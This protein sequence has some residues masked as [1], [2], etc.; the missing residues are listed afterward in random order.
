MKPTAISSWVLLI[1]KALEDSGQ[2][3]RTIFERA[4]L[5][6][7]L[8]SD[9]NARY[10]VELTTRLW[11]ISA[12][13]TGNPCFGIKA[14]SFWHPTTIHAL[15]YSW[16]ASESLY[17]ALTRAV[18]Y[19]RIVSSGAGAYL[20]ETDD[21]VQFVFKSRSKSKLADEAVDAGIALIVVMCR[22]SYGDNFNPLRI[23]MTRE[24][25]PCAQ[26]YVDYFKA[27]V[28]FSMPTDILY[29]DKAQ[30]YE[31]LPTGNAELARANDQ[32]I[33]EYLAHFDR[34]NTSLRVKIKLVERMPSGQVTE[35][36]I[37][38]TLNMSVR[39]LQ[40][41]LKEEGG[42][43]KEIL[44]ETREELAAQYMKNS[45]RSINEITYLLG[46]SEPSN[47]SRAFKRWTGRSPTRFRDE[48][49]A[50]S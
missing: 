8:L 6:Y 17:D 9:P 34:N 39:T 26:S 1:A 2:C 19:F 47:F 15:G 24:V 33:T 37:A 12:E 21:E 49:M 13:V 45:R 29:F 3:S 14:A 20:V 28:N 23:D 22:T 46:F 27:P 50:R 43:Y 5:D 11:K 40:R 38:K 44:D 35:E 4:G 30:V 18:R 25:L 10:P 32:I 31:K 16:M 41:K 42:S 36:S 7:S 48:L